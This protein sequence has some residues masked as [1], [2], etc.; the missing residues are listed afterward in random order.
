MDLGI[1]NKV[2]LV[3]GASRGI[4]PI[5]AQALAREGCRVALAARD[6][7][8]LD[9]RAAEIKAEGGEAAGFSFDLRMRESGAALVD[10][11]VRKFGQIDVIVANAGSAR[12][13]DFLELT[14]DQWEE[15]FA[16]KFFGQM[17]LIRAAWPVLKKSHGTIIMVAGSAG[18][19]P[20]IESSITGSVNS[21]MLNL[22]K[23]LAIRG[24]GDG[25]RINAINPGAFQTHRY[26]ERIAN[27]MKKLG[28][29]EAEVEQHLAAGRN[30]APLGNSEDMAGL[31]CFLASAQS[32]HIHGAVIDIDGGK[33]R[34]L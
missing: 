18:R 25:I 2:V 34:T 27:G 28:K 29:N 10:A 3:T 16:L 7:A 6:Q 14:D 32:K 1:K 19:T 20:S 9:Q 30:N 26:L 33:T 21:A 31:V 15:G 22:T 12:L 8:L 13:G 23:T 17:R 5:I 11:V 24:L 4:G